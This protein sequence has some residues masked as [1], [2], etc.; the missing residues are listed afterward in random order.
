MKIKINDNSTNEIH[1]TL[2]ENIQLKRLSNGFEK[3]S[4]FPKKT[5]NLLLK[6]YTFGNGLNFH[7][8]KGDILSLIEMEYSGNSGCI[9]YLFLK[10][11]ELILN[12]TNKLRTRLSN[13]HSAIV[14][15][16][17]HQKQIFTFP[18]QNNLE[19]FFI[20]INKTRFFSNKRA[21]YDGLPQELIEIF[22]SNPK[23]NH[24]LYQSYY[25]LNISEVYNEIIS[26]K[27]EGI[28]KRFFLE[29]KIFE[30]LWLQ[31]EQYKNELLYGYDANVLRKVDVE[32]IKKAKVFIHHNYEKKL[33]LNLLSV[34]IGTNET[35]LK[36]G[37][38]KMYGK[39]F[40]EILLNER[41]HK[42]KLL[43]EENKLSI[44]EV[45][46]ACGYKSAS[47]FSIRFKERFGISPSQ[48]K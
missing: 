31:T 34:T 4:T 18:V 47:M 21:D 27:A 7:V 28:L 10:R 22:S 25:S 46:N 45:A 9:Q 15:V 24:F 5:G 14:A 20:E 29:S 30:L 43:I 33:T 32:L 16:D 1:D 8:F 12:L 19:L 6:S 13:Y 44:K 2:K 23:E 11:G 41:L 38:K 37:F 17:G 40:T 48:Y 26:T 3:T 42:S 35:K 39:T 36:N